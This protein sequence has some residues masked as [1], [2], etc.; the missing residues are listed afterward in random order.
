M[1]LTK[2]IDY[3]AI[4]NPNIFGLT[5]KSKSFTSFETEFN[6]NFPLKETGATDRHSKRCGLLGYK[7][8][9]THFWNKWG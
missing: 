1:Q 2:A 3:S 7:I 6:K 4:I 9:M 5:N 8:G